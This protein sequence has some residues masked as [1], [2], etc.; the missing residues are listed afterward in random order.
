MK[1][2][3]TPQDIEAFAAEMQQVNW[4]DPDER[5]AIA[6]TILDFVK[7]DI[8]REDLEALLVDVYNFNIGE[9]PQW[10][11][12]KGLKAYVHEPGSY[13]PRST[14]TQKVMTITTEQVS[15]HPEFELNQL[16]AGRYGTIADVRQMAVEE[17]LGRKYSII[18]AT[19]LGSIASTDT[20]YATFASGAAAAT[21]K[22]ALDTAINYV[23]DKT[24]SG[25]KAIVGRATVLG[26][27]PD[28]T[29]WSEQTKYKLE[30]TINLGSYRGI[31]I[32]SLHQYTDGYGNKWITDNEILVLGS[33]STKL[34]RN[35][36]LEVLDDLN[37]DDKMWHLRMDEQYGV[38]VHYPTR[39]YRLHVS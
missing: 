38:V 39:N 12:R 37:I 21:K 13:S 3:I 24:P 9:S 31:P 2:Q 23:E 28:V 29:G 30:N 15:V 1:E 36:A 6:L 32:V 4:N 16:R 7:E 10:I 25:V 8:V 18:W 14:I 17:L 27:I 5:R 11:T 19:V 22:T 33:G 20:N 35:Q 26:W 34:G